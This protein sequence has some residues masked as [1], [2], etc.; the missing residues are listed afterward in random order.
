MHFG[1]V[2]HEGGEHAA[3]AQSMSSLLSSMSES[4]R[5]VPRIR[6]HPLR[7]I[8][9]CI[10]RWRWISVI[11]LLRGSHSAAQQESA[12]RREDLDTWSRHGDVPRPGLSDAWVLEEMAKFTTVQVRRRARVEDAWPCDLALMRSEEGGCVAV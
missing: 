8:R 6:I 5:F 2:G 3:D 11:D 7:L 12:R 1:L 10:G 4:L 9:S